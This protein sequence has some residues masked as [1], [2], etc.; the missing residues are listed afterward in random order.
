[1]KMMN[2][3]INRSKK[4]R[5]KKTVR[6]NMQERNR[7]KRRRDSKTNR[8]PAHPIIF[9]FPGLLWVFYY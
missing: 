3:K 5:Q 8:I 2:D 7:M 1:M 9:L 6:Y 4:E